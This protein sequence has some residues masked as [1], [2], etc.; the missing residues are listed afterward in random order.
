MANRYKGFYSYFWLRKS[1]EVGGDF[2]ALIRVL[3]SEI[4]RRLF[5]L[6]GSPEFPKVPEAL[7]VENEAERIF[8]LSLLVIQNRCPKTE[9][10]LLSLLYKL[11]GGTFSRESLKYCKTKFSKDVVG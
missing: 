10:S 9:R 6:L 8:Y 11:F 4:N 7:I 5:R 1:P 2:P 3:M